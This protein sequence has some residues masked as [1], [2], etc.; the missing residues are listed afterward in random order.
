MGKADHDG[1]DPRSLTLTLEMSTLLAVFQTVQAVMAG[2][3]VG[4][5]AVTGAAVFVATAATVH[6][7]V[8][9]KKLVD[10]IV[11][12][13]E[14][15]K[16][17][18]SSENEK[19]LNDTKD[20]DDYLDDESPTK[21]RVGKQ[22]GNTSRDREKQNKQSRDIANKLGLSKKQKRQLHDQISKQGYN[23]KEA[24]EEAEEMFGKNK[25]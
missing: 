11:D 7:V 17:E 13:V 14:K 1:H 6:N 22:K 18:K 2:V 21:T 10:A 19:G 5:V 15:N 20:G 3:S 24:L 12:A 16:S 25:K 9:C 23:Y 8:M 4:S